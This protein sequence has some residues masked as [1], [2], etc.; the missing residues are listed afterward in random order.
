[1]VLDRSSRRIRITRHRL[2]SAPAIHPFHRKHGFAV[3]GEWH[4]DIGTI[5][6]RQLLMSLELAAT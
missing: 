5:T 4:Y 2:G 3:I 6:Q 1:V